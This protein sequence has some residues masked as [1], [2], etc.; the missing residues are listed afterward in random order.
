[1]VVVARPD[2]LAA[3]LAQ[4]RASAELTALTSTR[5]TA[6]LQ[7]SWSGMPTYAVLVRPA[8]GPPGNR[9]VNLMVSRIDTFC[10]G[11]TEAQAASLWRLLD[12]VLC[13]GQEREVGFIRTVDGVRCRVASVD[14]ESMPT[15]GIED[16]TRWPRTTC[17]YLVR[18]LGVAL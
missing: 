10:Y 14:P 3:V 18:W 1:M 12:A 17:S 13:P 7:P 2:V 11:A 16:G 15:S 9:Q 4:L 8:G 6:R 5:I